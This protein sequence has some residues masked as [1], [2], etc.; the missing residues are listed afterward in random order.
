MAQQIMYPAQINSPST[1]LDGSITDIDTSITVF[2]GSKLPNAPNLLT[3]GTGNDAETILMTVKN[4]NTLTVTRGVQGTAKAWDSGEVISRNFTAYDHDTFKNNIEDLNSRLLD[5]TA[6]NILDHTGLP[7][8]GGGAGW[9]D[10]A[11]TPP[12]SPSAYNDEFDDAVIDTDWIQVY[13]PSYQQTYTES[14]GVMSVLCKDRGVVVSAL[15]KPFTGL[16]PP[17]TI[18]TAFRLMST[19]NYHSAG[20]IFS[21]GAIYGSGTKKQ[22]TA[23]QGHSAAIYQNI[24]LGEWTD[25]ITRNSLSEIVVGSGAKPFYYIRLI[26]VDV[27]IFRVQISP[28]GITWITPLADFVKNCTPDHFGIAMTGSD[29]D[30]SDFVS[31]FEYFRVIEE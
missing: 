13:T 19:G 10:V 15:V 12:P 9:S 5:E 8:C 29:G 30:G 21:E 4:G 11:L 25:Y 1:T 7:G 27:N 14:H 28:D 18:E 31:T 22:I 16:T 2:D 3:I 6:H 26:W 24:L 17:V 23:F 20:L